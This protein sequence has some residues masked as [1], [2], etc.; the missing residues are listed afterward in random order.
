MPEHN[1]F[2]IFISRL[3]KLGIQYMITGSVASIIYGE[4]RLTHDIDLVIELNKDD[5]ERFAEAFPIE[6]FYCP[7][8]EANEKNNY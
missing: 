1:L 4:P 5:A 2:Q 3:N 6:E 8:P 7:P